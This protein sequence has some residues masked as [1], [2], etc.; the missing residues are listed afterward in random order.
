MKS[1]RALVPL[2]AAVI[3]AVTPA[4]AQEED[5]TEWLITIQGDVSEVHD[6]GLTMAVP[7]NGIAFTDRPERRV[8][9]VDLA[10]FVATAWAEDGPLRADP[11]N[12]SLIDES[13]NAVAVVTIT[14][15]GYADGMLTVELTLLEG[16]LPA[17]GDTIALTI[18]AYPTA[19]NDQI[20]D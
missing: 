6:G 3:L 15:M 13:S 5:K 2:F 19:V 17:V 10:A 18:D 16:A 4:S 8:A 9:F 1:L 7:A 14:T 11:P 12:A 20:T